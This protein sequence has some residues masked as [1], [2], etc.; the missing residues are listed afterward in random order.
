MPKSIRLE[1]GENEVAIV[2]VLGDKDEADAVANF[3]AGQIQN[4]YLNIVVGV[5]LDLPE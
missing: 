4:N 3:L 5:D 1:R 2:F